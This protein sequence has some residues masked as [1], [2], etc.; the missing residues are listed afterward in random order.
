MVL[1]FLGLIALGFRVQHL[2]FKGLGLGFIVLG[3]GG[4]GF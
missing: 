3:S 4:L 2:G 1:G